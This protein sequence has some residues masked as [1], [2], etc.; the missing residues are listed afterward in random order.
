M[1]NRTLSE[2]GCGESSNEYQHGFIDS[3]NFDPKGQFLIAASRDHKVFERDV[4]TWKKQ[5]K[6][7]VGHEGEVYYSEY[8]PDGKFVISASE[9][10]KVILWEP[11]ATRIPSGATPAELINMARAR[12]YR[13]LNCDE[14]RRFQLP[15]TNAVSENCCCDSQVVDCN[16]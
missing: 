10:H 5:G 6:S 15:C 12:F 3:I 16:K 7:L 13:Q 9:D 11:R 14:L 1:P 2:Q 4:T 8:S